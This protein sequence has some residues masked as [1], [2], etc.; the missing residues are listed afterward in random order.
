MKK[1][2]PKQSATHEMKVAPHFVKTIDGR[3]VVGIAS[4]FG[5]LDSYNDRMWPGAFT[6]TLQERNGKIYHLWQHDFMQ[7]AIAIIRN[8]REIGRDELPPEVLSAAPEATGGLEVTREYLDTPRANEILAGLN[9]G[10]K[11]QMSFAYDPVKYDFE[12]DE[13]SMWGDIRN[14]REVRLY[15][16]SDVLWGANDATVASKMPAKVLLRQ[17]AGLLRDIKAGKRHSDGDMDL[18][19][20]IGQAALDLGATNIQLL[21]QESDDDDVQDDD[22]SKANDKPKAFDSSWL[23]TSYLDLAALEL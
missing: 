16:T 6:K 2:Q 20:Q 10:I 9:A 22:T 11:Y 23:H 21:E 12:E 19:N 17:A 8:L 13:D 15:E 18:I 5:N 1:K 3:T 14:L 7:P 4:V